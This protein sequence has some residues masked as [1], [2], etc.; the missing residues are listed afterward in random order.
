MKRTAFLFWRRSSHNLANIRRWNDD[1]I[2][3]F[4]SEDGVMGCYHNDPYILHLRPIQDYVVL[5][6]LHITGVIAERLPEYGQYDDRKYGIFSQLA[7]R[8]TLPVAKAIHS[9]KNDTSD[10]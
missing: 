4:C 1:D 9:P 6:T 8:H 5:K 7:I 10:K 3:L 2:A